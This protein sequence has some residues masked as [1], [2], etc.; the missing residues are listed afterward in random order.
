MKKIFFLFFS[1][2]QLSSFAQNIQILSK[3]DSTEIPYVNVLYFANDSIVGITETDEDGKATLEI[4]LP[5]NIIKFL[6]VGYDTVK[7]NKN[8]LNSVIYLEELPLLLHEIVVTSSKIKKKKPTKLGYPVRNKGYSYNVWGG[9]EVVALFK[10]NTQDQTKVSAF[11]FHLR[12]Y[13]R[14]D[15]Q[16]SVFRIVFYKNA[17]NKPYNQISIKDKKQQV[18]I[19]KPN[20]RGKIKLN[21]DHLNIILPK[22]GLFVGIEYMGFMEANSKDIQQNSKFDRNSF[23]EPF[24][25]FSKQKKAGKSYMTTKF[26]GKDKNLFDINAYWVGI[27]PRLNLKKDEYLTPAFAIEVYE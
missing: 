21:I 15:N 2:I 23:K 26:E 14:Q 18:F 19:L 8:D 13:E 9:F 27:F 7:T 25:S 16:S 10:P 24:V 12:D 3:Q 11:L 6:A 20:Q 4:P 22:E 1:F 17:A 5:C